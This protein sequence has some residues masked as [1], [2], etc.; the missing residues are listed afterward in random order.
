[1]II[2]RG[3]VRVLLV[4]GLVRVPELLVLGQALLELVPELL[5]LELERV[6]GPELPQGLLELG[7]GLAV[8]SLLQVRS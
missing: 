7:L 8:P 5:E 1:M 3:L 2:E 4:R 6:L